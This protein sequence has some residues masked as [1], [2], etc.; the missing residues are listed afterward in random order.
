M[1]EWG[2]GL[3][4]QGYSTCVSAPIYF[5]KEAFSDFPKIPNEVKTLYSLYFLILILKCVLE[6]L[7]SLLI[8]STLVPWYQ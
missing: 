7:F 1:A 4:D 8:L 5:H 2:N 6:T 3:S